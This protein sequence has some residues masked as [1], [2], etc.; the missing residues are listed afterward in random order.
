MK[1]YLFLEIT[2]KSSASHQFYQIM[3]KEELLTIANKKSP[4]F[5]LRFYE[6]S[7]Q[8][9]FFSNDFI[10]G[11]KSRGQWWKAKKENMKRAK[12]VKKIKLKAKGAKKMWSVDK[13]REK[14]QL[15]ASNS[16]WK[17]GS[18]Q[19]LEMILSKQFYTQLNFLNF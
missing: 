3:K 10:S 9:P 17:K 14:Y 16:T 1:K 19:Q 6:L 4:S 2:K 18:K 8:A 15:V 11:R 5:L 12:K 7:F 13:K